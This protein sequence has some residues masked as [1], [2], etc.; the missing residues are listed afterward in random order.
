MEVKAENAISLLDFTSAVKNEKSILQENKSS[1]F[2][3]LQDS[4]KNISIKNK[5]PKKFDGRDL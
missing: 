5:A 1:I 4:K 3:K 2:S